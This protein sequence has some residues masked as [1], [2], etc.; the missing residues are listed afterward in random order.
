MMCVIPVIIVN[1]CAHVQF[2]TTSTLGLLF[3]WLHMLQLHRSYF[4]GDLASS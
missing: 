4:F 2:V 3:S 1:P